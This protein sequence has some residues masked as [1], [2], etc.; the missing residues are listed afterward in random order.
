MSERNHLQ[1][2]NEER[3]IVNLYKNYLVL[4]EDLLGPPYNS[5]DN[6]NYKRI[7]KRVLDMGNDVLREIDE[8][9]KKVDITLK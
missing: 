6:E 7:R 5:L 9:F 2:S 1:L 8:D 3:R 4:L